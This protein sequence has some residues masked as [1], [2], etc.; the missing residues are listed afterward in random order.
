MAF[1]YSHT[2]DITGA[3]FYIGIG[4]KDNFKRAYEKHKRSSIWSEI[5]KSGYSINII[6]NGISWEDACKI[7][8]DLIRYYGR[9]DLKTGTLCNRTGGGQGAY[10]IVISEETRKKISLRKKGVKRGSPSIESRIKQSKALKGKLPKNFS[11]LRSGVFEEKRLKALKGSQTPESRKIK[12]EKWSNEGNPRSK[13][14]MNIQNGIYY[15]N[16]QAA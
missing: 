14:V 10:G 16:L 9:L 1:V 11:Y 12:S 2:S 5:A 15:E 7:E 13:I 3:I 8:I 6:R 4:S